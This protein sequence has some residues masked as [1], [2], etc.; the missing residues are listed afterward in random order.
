VVADQDIE[1]H[2]IEQTQNVWCTGA[3]DTANQIETLRQTRS[4]FVLVFRFRQHAQ[5]LAKVFLMQAQPAALCL[6]DSVIALDQQE[7]AIQHNMNL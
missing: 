2:T 5:R 6:H 7:R 1:D 3:C 4:T